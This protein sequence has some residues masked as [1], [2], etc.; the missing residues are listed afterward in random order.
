LGPEAEGNTARGPKAPLSIPALPDKLAAGILP[1]KTIVVIADPE[2]I[3][4]DDGV[5]IAV[6]VGLTVIVKVTGVPLQFKPKVGVTVMVATTG[7]LPALVAVKLAML[8]EPLAANPMDGALF[9][10][11]NTVPA[12][13]PEKVTAEVDVPLHTTWLPTALTETAGQLITK[14]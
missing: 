1:V 9:V 12:G 2:Q 7:E 4:W 14:L 13:E 11:L 5:A 3:V 6:G 8:P 10:Q